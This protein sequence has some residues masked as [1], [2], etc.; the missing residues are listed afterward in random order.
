MSDTPLLPPLSPAEARQIDQTCDHFEAAWKAGRRPQP[1]DY[2]GTLGEPARSYL[3]RQLLFLDWDYRL[4]A[5]EAPRASEYI[6]RFPSDPALVENVGSVMGESLVSTCEWSGEPH[7]GDTPLSGAGSPDFAGGV[8]VPVETGADRY[9]LV[10]EVGHG[11]M[12]VVF[13]GRDRH[14]GRELAVK[15]LREAHRDNPEARRR[16]LAEARVGSQLQHPAIVPVYEQGWFDKRRPYFT[17]KL[18]EGHT[19][20]ALL[21][22]RGDPGQNLPR[23]LGIYE[24]VCQ[25]M[26]YAHAR[27][28][29]HRDLKPANVMVGAFGE[30][31]VMDWG[32]VKLFAGNGAAPGV[33]SP[34]EEEALAQARP[35]LGGNGVSQSG[36]LLGTPAYMSP[37][38]A[39]GEASLID[40]RADVFALGAILCEILTGRPPYAGS[41][42]HE[43]CGKAAEGDLADAHARLDACGADAALRELARRCLAAERTARPPDAGAV[44]RDVTAYLTSAQERLRQAQLERTA[45]E[46]RAEEAQAK[47]R[48]ERRARRLTLALAAALFLGIGVSAWQAVAATRAEHNAVAAAVAEKE[49][50]E[51]ADAKE[52]ETRSVLDFVQNYIFAAARPEGQAGGLGQDVSLRLALEAALPV[53]ETHFANQPLV[54]A[55]LRLTL[56][57]SFRYL[58]EAQIAADQFGRARALYAAHLGP[59]DPATLESMDNLAAAYGDLDRQLEALALREETLSRRKDRLGPD[60]PDTFRSM[61]SLAN[62]YEDIGWHDDALKLYEETLALQKAKL[63]PDHSDTLSSMNSLALCYSAHQRYADALALHKET[64]ARRQARLGPGHPDTLASMI[65]LANSYVD[66]RDYEGALKLQQETLVLQKAKLGPQHPH[67]IKTIYNLGNTYG[68]LERYEEALKFHQE[69]FELRKAKFGPDHRSTL[70]SMWGVAA[71]LYMVGRGA[72]AVAMTDECIERAARLPVQP[73]LVGL[74][75]RRSQ[76]FEKAKDAAGCRKTAE[77][78]E[79]LRR[80]DP[81]SLYNAACYRA[82]TA[83]VIRATDQSPDGVREAEAEADRAMAWLRQAAAAG[84][85]NVALMKKDTDLD[86]LRDRSDFQQLCASLAAKSP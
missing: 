3:L 65:N 55:R 14:L 40:P 8:D 12:G 36:V 15:V 30:V 34:G 64:L 29:V 84:Y 31:Q 22:E 85:K 67:T 75:N 13:R 50:K 79:K 78:W 38:Q 46:A 68:W 60:H 52:A 86:A 7:A 10:Q 27:G 73:D 49:A 81:K 39:R 35:V 58:G 41:T 6:V 21:R 53:V 62:S 66:L 32:F 20:A 83:K 74:L 82:V 44:A 54:E 4:R 19:L 9:D 5:G 42:A 57:T 71:Q 77:A 11:G 18:V 1:D 33:S 51:T 76:Y 47:A 56:G 23:L 69:A 80:T 61:H 17:M 2:L 59:D 45:A 72:D 48:A 28:V 26:A 24:Q 70:W 25:A 37:E 43:V 16:F 63:G